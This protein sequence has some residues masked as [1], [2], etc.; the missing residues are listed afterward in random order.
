MRELERLGSSI[1]VS[2]PADEDGY[3]GRECPKCEGYFKITSGTGLRGHG[4]PCHCPYCGHRE[5][6]DHFWTKQQIAYAKSVAMQKVVGAIQRDLKKLE[7]DIKPRRGFGIGISMKMKPGPLPP[8]RYYREKR[9]ETAVECD[10]CTLKYMIYG[11]F[12]FCPDCGVHNSGQILAKNLDLVEKQ[13]ALASQV[14]AD[15]ADHLIGDGLENA[16][17]SFDGFGRE[18]CKVVAGKATDQ[19]KAANLSFQN[20]PGAQKN[21]TQLFAVDLAVGL[22]SCDWDF[23]YKCFQKRHLLAHKMGIVDEAYVNA[24]HDPIAVVGRKVVIAAPDVARLVSCL[25]VLSQ[26]LLSKLRTLP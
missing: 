4:L 1:R 8:I 16:V 25:R 2:I 23:V 6:H 20:L 26:H 14:E 22:P 19:T 17:S 12:A 10:S 9:L 5:G 21:L 7:F 3:T 13:L 11:V 24:T 15:L 18:A